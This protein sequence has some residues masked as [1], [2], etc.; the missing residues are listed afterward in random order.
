MSYQTLLLKDLVDYDVYQDDGISRECGLKKIAS[1][2]TTL[3]PFRIL[4]HCLQNLERP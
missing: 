3:K 1:R 2:A 4:R